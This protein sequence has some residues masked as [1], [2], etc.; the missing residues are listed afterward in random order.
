MYGVVVPLAE[1]TRGQESVIFGAE[2]GLG[3]P[4]PNRI[5]DPEAATCWSWPATP[6]VRALAGAITTTQM[7]GKGRRSTF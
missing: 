3:C 5:P 1:A 7:R 2:L 4:T 6:T